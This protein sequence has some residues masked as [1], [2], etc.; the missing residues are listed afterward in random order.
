MAARNLSRFFERVKMI[1][2]NY[3]NNN[4]ACDATILACGGAGFVEIV[5]RTPSQYDDTATAILMTTAVAPCGFVIGALAGGV[6]YYAMPFLLPGMIGAT[7]V[8][9]YQTRT[10]RNKEFER[11]M[12]DDF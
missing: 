5:L 3:F 10:K 7:A 2:T 12:K 1:T 11:M 9:L 6:A 4:A 8:K